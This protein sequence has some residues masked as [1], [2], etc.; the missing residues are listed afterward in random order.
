[1]ID[2]ILKDIFG[3]SECTWLLSW[4]V[5]TAEHVGE[6]SCLSGCQEYRYLSKKQETK[7]RFFSFLLCCK[8]V[9]YGLFFQRELTTWSIYREERERQ[10]QQEVEAPPAQSTKENVPP[11][12][13]A[14]VFFF[15]SFCNSLFVVFNDSSS[16]SASYTFIY[17]L[18]KSVRHFFL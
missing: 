5:R 15:Y 3:R 12:G 6:A 10:K 17:F 14:K 4:P 2:F 18:W 9:L 13:M 7:V 16:L 1:M 8:Y 11:S